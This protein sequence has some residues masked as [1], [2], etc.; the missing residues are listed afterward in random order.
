MAMVDKNKFEDDGKS[1]RLTSEENKNKDAES[2]ESEDDDSSNDEGVD[3]KIDRL[4]KDL[5]TQKQA[6]VKLHQSLKDL[7]EAT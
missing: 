4:A 1:V 2:Y 6:N 7:R 5:L 3:I